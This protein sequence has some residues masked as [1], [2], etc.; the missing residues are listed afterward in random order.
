MTLSGEETFTPGLFPRLQEK[1]L[2]GSR[3]GRP[4]PA[5]K[6]EE[7][8]VPPIPTQSKVSNLPFEGSLHPAGLRLG[9]WILEDTDTSCRGTRGAPKAQLSRTSHHRGGYPTA[10][11]VADRRVH[12]QNPL[13]HKRLQTF[14]CEESEAGPVREQGRARFRG[15][16]NC[17]AGLPSWQVYERP[18]RPTSE[19]TTRPCRPPHRR[20]RRGDLQSSE[21]RDPGERPPMTTGGLL[22]APCAPPPALHP[23]QAGPRE[24]GAGQRKVEPGRR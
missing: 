9:L 6:G 5:S 14:P 19:P 11:T 1:Q 24:S 12:L 16:V 20:G 2:Q 15:A 17:K 7:L 3:T 13:G 8:W 4:G 22:P 18:P 23:R 10:R 21:T